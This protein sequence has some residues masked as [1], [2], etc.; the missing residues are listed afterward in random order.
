MSLFDI[1]KKKKIERKPKREEPK[2][3]PVKKA[4]K[5]IE[6]IK[7]AA[8]EKKIVAG[9]LRNPCITEKASFLGGL[10]Q[11]VFKVYSSANKNQIKK[12][13]E[14][15]YAVNVKKVRVINVPARPRRLGRTLGTKSGYKKAI[16][17]L[18]KGEKIEIMPH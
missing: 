16:V 14:S 7:P 5:I 4:A 9:I 1:F 12:A 2:K 18:K 3:T 17:V 6:E 11:Y 8:K 10:N 15:F 13:V